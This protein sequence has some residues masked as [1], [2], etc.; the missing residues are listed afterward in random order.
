MGVYED[1]WSDEPRTRVR[2][3]WPTLA[4]AVAAVVIAG[5]ALWRQQA[6]LDAADAAEIHAQRVEHELAL[7]QTDADRTNARIASTQRAIS[8]RSANVAPL[9]ARALRSVFTVDAGDAIGSGFVAW[10]NDS[11]SYLLTANH[12]VEGAGDTV[13][14]KRG[15]GSWSA[16]VV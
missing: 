1:A 5:A 6:A 15:S 8:K 2:S 9:A 12:V 16:D 3:Q 4:L 7:I 10:A 11:G 14:I 13:T